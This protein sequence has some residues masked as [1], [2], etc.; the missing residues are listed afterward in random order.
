MPRVCTFTTPV[1]RGDLPLFDE[2]LFWTDDLPDRR[3]DPD[4][5]DAK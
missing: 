3:G 2:A 1:P 4:A 5:P